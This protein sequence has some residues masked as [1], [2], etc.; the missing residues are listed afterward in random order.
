MSKDKKLATDGLNAAMN[1]LLDICQQ[2]DNNISHHKQLQADKI[3]PSFQCN[4]NKSTTS[5]DIKLQNDEKLISDLDTSTTA[6]RCDTETTMSGQNF[7]TS[8]NGKGGALNSLDPREADTIER[9]QQRQAALQN[10]LDDVLNVA[11]ELELKQKKKLNNLIDDMD[12]KQPGPR[13][14]ISSGQSADT[15]DDDEDIEL[16][17]FQQI[18]NELRVSE[19]NRQLNNIQ[20]ELRLRLYKRLL[21]KTSSSTSSSKSSKGSSQQQHSPHNNNR[22]SSFRRNSAQTDES[23]PPSSS[24]SDEPTATS[25]VSTNDMTH[26]STKNS[27][28]SELVNQF[29]RCNLSARSS[30]L[31]PSTRQT[32]DHVD[33]QVGGTN[34]KTPDMSNSSL[35]SSRAAENNDLEIAFDDAHN[36]EVLGPT[37]SRQQQTLKSTSSKLTPSRIPTPN[38]NNNNF[39]HQYQ[40][41]TAGHAAS[42]YMSNQHQVFNGFRNC[43]ANNDLERI[44]E[45]EE[46]DAD[47]YCNSEKFRSIYEEKISPIV[48]ASD[49]NGFSSHKNRRQPQSSIPSTI[50]E[51]EDES[52]YASPKPSDDRKFNINNINSAKRGN[53]PLTMYL[54]KPDEEI[55]LIETVQS[56]GHDLDILSSDL[57]IDSSSAK[58]YLY[59]SCSNNEKKWLKR[60][61]YFD[62][63][64]KTL[65][66]Y[67]SEEQLV[68]K[69]NSP[70]CT[71]PFDEISDVYVDHRL[72]ELS[73]KQRGTR[74]KS[75]I[76]VLATIKRKFLLASTKAETMRAWIDVLFTAAKANDYFQQIE[77]TD[78]GPGFD[79]GSFT[80]E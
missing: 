64:A 34:D 63:A 71:I 20:E 56:L 61:F 1:E 35:K 25:S 16:I 49:V 11:K 59:K 14:M 75:Y 28:E 18:E 12:K 27:I 10:Q 69:I 45:G 9:L 62:R 54:P 24:C 52:A 5:M 50:K 39:N 36:Y 60:F 58:G 46:D 70:K 41:Y 32:V 78:E 17:E 31:H 67:D 57:K 2:Y 55:D 15:D 26:S 53:R 40:T 48:Q 33:A 30:E 76:F 21:S 72:S 38:K 47:Y 8:T 44:E 13:S 42:E 29:E 65:S 43:P 19:L 66:Y 79:Y 74:R 80:A 4:V 37:T 73:E 22:D 23:T 6:T 51:A 68:K 77:E 3:T 7:T